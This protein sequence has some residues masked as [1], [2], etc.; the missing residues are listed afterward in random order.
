MPEAV[1]VSGRVRNLKVYGHI[2]KV[3]PQI[4]MNPYVCGAPMLVG[5]PG[6]YPLGPCVKTAL[7][8]VQK[9]K[10]KSE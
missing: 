9:S 4:S 6:K 5:P 7:V 10:T 8:H 1:P 2:N 3:S